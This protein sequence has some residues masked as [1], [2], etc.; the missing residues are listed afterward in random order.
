M[1]IHINKKEVE[2][3][4]GSRLTDVAQREKLPNKGVAIAVNNELVCCDDWKDHPLR[5]GDDL[6]IIKAFCGG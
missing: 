4:E 5:E 1:K 2:L 6:L 3:P